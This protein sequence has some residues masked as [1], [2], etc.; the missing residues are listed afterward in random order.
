MSDNPCCETCR[1]SSYP[2]THNY[3]DQSALPV[4][5]VRCHRRA[6]TVAGGQMSSAWTAWPLV[7][8]TEWCGEWEVARES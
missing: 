5:H 8:P 3:P 2:F 7:R 6:P 1:F 4:T